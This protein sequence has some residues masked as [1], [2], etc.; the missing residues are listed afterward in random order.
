MRAY[1]NDIDYII[2]IGKYV[3]E[4][5]AKAGLPNG[6]NMYLGTTNEID[7]KIF[8]TRI[9]LESLP[10]GVWEGIRIRRKLIKEG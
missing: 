5:D 4:M 8:G 10:E 9:K 6:V 2:V 7:R 3:F 1:K